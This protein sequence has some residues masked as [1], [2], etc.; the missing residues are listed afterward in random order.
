MLLYIKKIKLQNVKK[1]SRNLIKENI[2]EETPKDLNP[3]SQLIQISQAKK[4]KEPVY[5]LV[6]EKGGPRRREFF[7]QVDF[8][9]SSAIGSGPN[10]KIAKR[11]AATSK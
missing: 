5:T 10:K 2:V 4:E 3:I 8:S 7:I 6:E 1:K 11:N 9:D